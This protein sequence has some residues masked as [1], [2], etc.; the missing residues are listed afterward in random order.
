MRI[1]LLI[2]LALPSVAAAELT[3]SR[4]KDALRA[5]ALNLVNEERRAAGLH[6]LALDSYTSIL[7]DEYSSRQVNDLTAGH[8]SLDGTA[9]Y[10]R[11]PWRGTRDM[12]RENVGSWS[13]NYS[14]APAVITDMIGRSHRTM[15]SETPPDD[16]HRRAILDPWATHMG[17]G[18]AWSRGEL[19][20]TQLFVRR[21]I[22]W[23]ESLP[24]AHASGA[25]AVVAGR[26]FP[27]ASV[28]AVS[29]HWEPLPRPLTR[30]AIGRRTDY[31]LP[32][33]RVELLPAAAVGRPGGLA[34][35]ARSLVAAPLTIS[36]DG[37]FRAR[38]TFD[39]GP[40]VYTVVTWVR[41]AQ[42]QPFAAGLTSTRVDPSFSSS[43]GR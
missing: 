36:D 21:W 40:G 38:I 39:R 19:R 37:S 10:M 7:A 6:P 23:T 22:D 27:G 34:A 17:F 11:Y 35:A 24:A 43:A 1:L 8:Y 42:E 5:H 3:S 14:F 4:L 12:I 9:P 25:D 26:P 2:L 41:R 13:A 33:N 28:A 15:M 29:V 30:S 16:G 31:S 32:E 20:F 18:I